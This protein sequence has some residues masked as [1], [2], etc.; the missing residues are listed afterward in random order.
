MEVVNEFV[1][2]VQFTAALSV[3]AALWVTFPAPAKKYWLKPEIIDRAIEF[4]VVAL[5]DFWLVIIPITYVEK[6]FDVA[7]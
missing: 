6:E 7:L 5:P 2:C 4:S 3:L 1:T